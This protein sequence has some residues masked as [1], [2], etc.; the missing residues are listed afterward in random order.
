MPY[1]NGQT[2]SK[3]FAGRSSVLSIGPVVGTETPTFTEIGEV[4]NASISG[5]KYSTVDV[6]NF[7]SPNAYQEFIATVIDPGSIS[8]SGNYV[9]SDAG[10]IALNAA[11][12]A[13]EVYMFELQLPKGPGQMTKG[14]QYAFGALV[15]S[16]DISVEPSKE[17]SFTASLKISGAITF[18][19]G[20]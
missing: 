5:R 7:D 20:S 15:E 8:C 1:P 3:A 9:S 12:A 6:T 14:D 17:I 13:G 19:A 16:F 10:Q 2:N 11:F 4:K 18:T